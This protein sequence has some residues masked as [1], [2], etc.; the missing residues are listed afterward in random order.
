[1]PGNAPPWRQGSSPSRALGSPGGWRP[2]AAPTSAAGKARGN[3]AITSG[4]PS[5]P[6]QGFLLPPVAPGS[7][8]HHTGCALVLDGWGQVEA[9]RRTAGFRVGSVK[10]SV[11]P[12]WGWARP[13]AHL[14]FQPKRGGRRRWRREAPCPRDGRR[15]TLVFNPWG[16]L[17]FSA[18]P[19]SHSPAGGGK[20][21]ASGRAPRAAP[22]GLEDHRAWRGAAPAPFPREAAGRGRRESRSSE[23]LSWQ[24][25][26][27]GKPDP[28][29]HLRPGAGAGIL[30]GPAK[31]GGTFL[32]RKN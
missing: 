20:T 14:G 8:A 30:N 7:G 23:S 17:G 12:W 22:K 25:A 28:V 19:G 21:A 2:A 26:N 16:R 9:F 15:R 3:P 18:P 27:S 1:M 32:A 5:G 10:G 11:G 6:F 31:R 29:R 13:P 4:G 24:R